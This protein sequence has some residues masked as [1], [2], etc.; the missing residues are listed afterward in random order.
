MIFITILLAGCSPQTAN[1]GNIPTVN[2]I[3]KL[4]VGKHSKEYVRSLLGTPS[5]RGTFDN[6]VWY[7]IGK[8]TKKWAFFEES[9][10]QQQVVAVYFNP[11]G[12]IEYIQTYDENDRRDIDITEGKT[13]TTGHELGVIEQMIGNL[14]RFNRPS[15]TTETYRY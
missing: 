12:T 4:Q 3:Q 13:P 10:I 5:T 2:Q 11:K 9:I 14:G 7:Y 6:D 8:R 1:R 15:S